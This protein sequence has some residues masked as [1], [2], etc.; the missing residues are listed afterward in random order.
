MGADKIGGFVGRNLVSGIISDSLTN[1]TVIGNHFVG[2][3]AGE[4]HGV[5][6][7]CTNTALV[8]TES[9]QN[10]VALEDITIDNLLNTEAADTA[11]DIGGIVGLNSGVLRACVNKASIGYTNMGYNIGGIAGTQMGYIVDCENHATILGRKEVGGIVGQIEPNMLLVYEEDGLQKLRVQLDELKSIMH[12]FEKDLNDHA[13][14]LNLEIDGM[15][16]AMERAEAALDILAKSF[17]TDETENELKGLNFDEQKLDQGIAAF[18]ELSDALSDM[19]EHAQNLVNEVD[20]TTQEVSDGMNKIFAQ[21]DA[22]EETIDAMEENIDIEFKDISDSDTEDDTLGKV[23][24]SI[25]YGNIAGDMNIGGIV[26]LMGKEND[27]DEEEDITV[28]GESSLKQTYHYR[29]VVRKCE[30]FG[31]VRVNKQYLGGIAGQMQLGCVLESKNFGNVD[32]TKADYVGGIV[33]DSWSIIRNSH[34]KC[35]ITGERYVGGIA[36]DADVVTD[37]YAFIELFGYTEFYGGILGYSQVLPEEVVV[38][39]ADIRGNYYFI[40]GKDVG[41]IDAICYKGA[42][43]PRSLVDF[44]QLE[45]LDE[46]FLLVEVRFVAEGQDDIVFVLTPGEGLLLEDIPEPPEKTG[47][48]GIWKGLEEADLDTVLFDM[49]FEASYDFYESVIEAEQISDKGLAILLAEGTF[50]TNTV[51]TIIDM[52]KTES[53]INEHNVLSFWNVSLNYEGDVTLHYLLPEGIKMENADLLVKNSSG[54]WTSR[55]YVVDGTY[56]VFDFVKGETDFC[57]IEVQENDIS[58]LFVI[59][60]VIIIVIMTTVVLKARVKKRKSKEKKE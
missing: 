3:F 58:W 60:I 37:C 16:E 59:L 5:I 51:L 35:K 11:T 17:E 34:V 22:I 20:E 6:S 31:M 9:R 12:T 7:N 42:A 15:Q 27:F 13:T 10:D 24:T 14:N 44:M 54:N 49:T 56:L 33:G 48:D 19:M 47:K 8:N 1:G 25:N 2:G 40:V 45:G 23:A 21:I 28:S 30:N 32:G 53:K 50:P 57:I 43:E 26:G 18:N 46:R 41:G 39:T 29:A 55:E 4:N 36:G 38:E 52:T